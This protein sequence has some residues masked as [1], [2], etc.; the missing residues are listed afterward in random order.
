MKFSAATLLLA[1]LMSGSALAQQAV[2]VNATFGY[3]WTPED[4]WPLVIFGVIPP[5]PGFDPTAL[6]TTT[7]GAAGLPNGKVLAFLTRDRLNTVAGSITSD[8]ATLI[9]SPDDAVFLSYDDIPAGFDPINRTA[10]FGGPLEVLGGTGRF[11]GATGTLTIRSHV[12]FGPFV[13]TYEIKG[14]IKT[15]P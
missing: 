6:V 9:F 3:Q 7:E 14:V 8:Y 4:D 11:V 10:S 15:V 12:L 13:G 5:P 2:P 1:V